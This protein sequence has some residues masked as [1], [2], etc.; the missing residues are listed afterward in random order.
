MYS[1][2]PVNHGD[3]LPLNRM[4]LFQCLLCQCWLFQCTL[5]TCIP[6][7]LY[8]GLQS[9]HC[10][11]PCHSCRGCNTPLNWRAQEAE[12]TKNL[13]CQMTVPVTALDEMQGFINI[14]TSGKWRVTQYFAVFSTTYLMG[15][16]CLAKNVLHLF[17]KPHRVPC[18]RVHY[19]GLKWFAATRG[20]SVQEHLHMHSHTHTLCARWTRFD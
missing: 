8:S 11:R 1:P 16:P 4:V 19:S 3:F 18:I 2:G 15:L 12:L 7:L 17:L 13:W 20:E 6:V 9:S 10:H 14:T 5:L